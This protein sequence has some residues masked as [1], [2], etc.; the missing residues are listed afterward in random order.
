MTAAAFDASAEEEKRMRINR[1]LRL[2]V[3]LA[4]GATLAYGGDL[5][6]YQAA[7]REG[8][9]ALRGHAEERRGDKVKGC[10][11]LSFPILPLPCCSL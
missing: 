7:V 6:L 1:A 5:W 11:C 2:A 4:A 8:V 10:D 3:I 9:A